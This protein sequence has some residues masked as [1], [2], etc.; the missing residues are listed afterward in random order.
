MRLS[1]LLSR[2]GASVAS[3]STLRRQSSLIASSSA[4]ACS[5]AVSCARRFQSAA[6]ATSSSDNGEFAHINKNLVWSL[7]NEGNLF[8]LSVQELSVFL[9]QHCNAEVDPKSKKS[10]LVRQVE[11]ILTSEQGASFTVPQED[12]LSSAAAVTVTEND[13]GSDFFDDSDVYGDWGAE[14]N[15]EDKR[16]IDFMDLSPSK[17]GHHYEALAPRAFQ[18]LHE[19]V[20]PDIGLASFN[21]G[22]LPGQKKNTIAYTPIQVAAADANKIRFRRGLQWCMLNLWNMNMPGE[23]NIGAGKVLYWRDVAK[24]N[25]NVL[26]LWT[27]QSHLYNNHP[28]NWFAVAPQNAVQTAEGFA[29]VMGMTLSQDATTSYKVTIRKG[30]ELM[31]CELNSLLRCTLLN[32]PWDR[33]LVSH[34]LRNKAPDLRYL[35]RARHAVKKRIADLYLDADILR[36]TRDSVQSVLSP[37]L[38]DVAYC[39]ERVVRKWSVPITEKGPDGAEKP[40]GL[41]LQLVETKRTPLIVTRAGDEGSRMEYELIVSLPQQSDRVDAVQLA[42]QLWDFGTQFA[43]YFEPVMSELG[44]ITMPSS[45]SFEPLNNA[46]P[47]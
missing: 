18:L 3:S 36:S 27:L 44:A 8:S 35:I 33:F 32:R 19:G 5:S 13:R 24:N 29:Q 31:D 10:A 41:N 2:K 46:A 37:E 38:G 42:D 6:Q 45:A 43:E 21:P 39:C 4:A 47:Q 12:T 15:F 22:K 28:Y 25:R 11:E 34:Y 17:M 1:R 30:L 20:T 14:P 26:P 40:T 9:S 7:W 23:L 16:D